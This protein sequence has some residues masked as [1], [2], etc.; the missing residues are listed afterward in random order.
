MLRDGQRR[1][2]KPFDKTPRQWVE[3]TQNA[4]AKR[5]PIAGINKLHLDG[6]NGEREFI[7]GTVEHASDIRV[8]GVSKRERRKR[9]MVFSTRMRRWEKAVL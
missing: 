4:A 3:F 1:Q 8:I 9:P 7:S 5:D 6:L 2:P